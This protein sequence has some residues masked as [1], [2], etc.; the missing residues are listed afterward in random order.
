VRPFANAKT[1]YGVYSAYVSLLSDFGIREVF[2]DEAN[3]F[4]LFQPL[5]HFSIPLQTFGLLRNSLKP[6]TLQ[7]ISQSAPHLKVLPMDV[8]LLF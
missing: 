2:E 1:I 8:E 4:R 5:L 6:V 7:S 3:D